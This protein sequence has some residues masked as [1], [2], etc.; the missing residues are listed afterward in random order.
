MASYPRHIPAGGE[1]TI[2][3]KVNTSG[4][5]GRQIK[6]NISVITDDPQQPQINLVISGK[7]NNFAVI[8]PRF[9]HLTGPAGKP[10]KVDVDIAPEDQ[11]PFKIL[12]VTAQNG[13]NIKYRLARKNSQGHERY[14][15]TV[16]NTK[17]DKGRYADT[18]LLQ[19][20]SKVKPEIEIRVY[21][22][23]FDPQQKKQG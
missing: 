14:V 5:G 1:G 21:G 8:S 3:I 20:D 22:N 16:E 7:V 11:Y 19:T 10:L 4:Y 6:K 12:N 9:A 15:L 13:A 2:K 18:I 23:I 17:P